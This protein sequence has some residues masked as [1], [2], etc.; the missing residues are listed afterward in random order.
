MAREALGMEE[1]EDEHGA[2]GS[3]APT[4][5]PLSFGRMG[6]GGWPERQC[7]GRRRS[8]A[9]TDV[10]LSSPSFLIRENA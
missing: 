5:H 3:H 7:G 2:V 10:L 8:V 4:P 9:P 6:E 1:E